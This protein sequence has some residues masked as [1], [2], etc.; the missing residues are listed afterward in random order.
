MNPLPRSTRQPLVW[1]FFVLAVIGAVLIVVL[2]RLSA[3]VDRTDR[4]VERG[5]FERLTFQREMV[6]I[7]RDHR[8]LVCIDL[9]DGDTGATDE[10]YDECAADAI[11]LPPEPKEPAS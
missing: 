11:P 9:A 10:Q 7:Q 2:L 8:R 3:A 4:S 6:I 1:L 5:R